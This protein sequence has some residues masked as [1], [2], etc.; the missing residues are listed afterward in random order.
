MFEI[1]DAARRCGEQLRTTVHDAVSDDA[2]QLELDAEAF[3]LTIHTG[4]T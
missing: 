2:I 1:R 4:A 3:D